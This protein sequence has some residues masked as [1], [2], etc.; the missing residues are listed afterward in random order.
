MIFYHRV[1]PLLLSALAL[2]ACD[3]IGRDVDLPERPVVAM[4]RFPAAIQQQVGDALATL[5]KRP[6]NAAA[7]GRVGMLLHTYDLLN[8]AVVFYKRAA[9]LEDSFRWPYL[10]AVAL[11]E[12]GEID[13]AIADLDTTLALEPD[14][15]RADIRR[16]ELTLAAGRL[17][18]ADAALKRIA[19][20]LPDRPEPKFL[21]GQLALR[22]GQAESAI[23]AF[24][25]VRRTSG[26]FTALHHA[27]AQAHRLLGDPDAMRYHTNLA[28]RSRDARATVPDPV[29]S[30]VLALDISTTARINR[31]RRLAMRGKEDAA[32]QELEAALTDTPDQVEIHITL[33]GM[34]GGRGDFARAD[35]HIARALE[36]DA[37]HPGVHYSRGVARIAEKRLVD[38]ESSFRKTLSL[39]PQHADAL[40]QL[41]IVQAMR[42][43][44]DKAARY[45]REALVK[46]PWN[47][48]ASWLLGRHLLAQGQPD[49]AIELLSPLGVLRDPSLGAILMDLARAQLAVGNRQAAVEALQSAMDAARQ[50]G[51]SATSSAARTLLVSVKAKDDGTEN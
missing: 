15:L 16:A 8:G 25:D 44:D 46:D 23:A 11:A 3:R 18:E 41:G 40:T 10:R 29:M 2:T 32:L 20:A 7:N 27:L 6:D 21:A 37:T 49:A 33:A 17:D 12:L 45:F 39:D 5:E 31:A 4:D 43:K 35:Q 28:E 14:Y 36:I 30:E 48:Q 50:F 22:R 9:L 38:A 24:E 13:A 51:D 19:R 1:F 42:G 47:R 34:M 26:D